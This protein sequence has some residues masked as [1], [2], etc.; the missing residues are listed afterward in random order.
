MPKQIT[1]VPPV[2]LNIRFLLRRT[3]APTERWAH[4]LSRRTRTA[5]SMIRA[6]E[7]IYGEGK[8]VTDEELGTIGDAF[9]RDAE[10]LRVG[11][12]YSEGPEALRKENLSFL[13]DTLPRGG[14]KALATKLGIRQATVTRWVSEGK[15]PETKNL[16]GLLK[17]LGLD[18]DLD[19]AVEPLFLSLQP[20][21]GFL[22]RKWLLERLESMTEEEITRFFPA[23]ARIVGSNDKN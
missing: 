11:C 15:V 22:Q 21:G 7:I 14:R 2:V 9:A 10:E 16:E 6:K 19:L 18:P 5:I 8:A 17:H 13:L 3:K 23:L 20:V 1:S 4:E 12:L